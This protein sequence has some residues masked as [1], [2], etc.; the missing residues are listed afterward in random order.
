M[1][2]LHDH[3][4]NEIIKRDDVDLISHQIS[5]DNVYGHLEEL[6]PFMQQYMWI[7]NNKLKDIGCLLIC[8]NFLIIIKNLRTTTKN[9]LI[10]LARLRVI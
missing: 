7:V 2:R 9:I 5:Y 10:K 1:R 3:Q 4:E 6:G 8:I